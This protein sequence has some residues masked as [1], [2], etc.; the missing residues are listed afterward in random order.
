[1][2]MAPPVR[3]DRMR[4]CLQGVLTDALGPDVTVK[5]GRD[6]VQRDSTK[7]SM[8]SLTTSTGALT[9]GNWRGRRLLLSPIS[10]SFTVTSATIGVLYSLYLNGHPYRHEVTG[11]ETVDDVRDSLLAK[12]VADS[13]SPYGAASGAS[14]ELIVTGDYA[15]ALFQAE[16]L[17]APDWTIAQG[18]TTVTAIRERPSVTTLTVGSYS[19]GVDIFDGASDLDARV[20][21]ALSQQKYQTTFAN[22]GVS[23]QSRGAP[24]DISA[25]A[26][27]GW[28]TRITR[29]LGIGMRSISTE[30]TESIETAAMTSI[31]NTSTGQP[32][33]TQQYTLT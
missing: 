17:P 9:K 33:F 1:M 16:A 29:D 8:V 5:W 10:I 30:V 19:K 2:I 12:V 22:F 25:I 4:E 6:S 31:F 14:G 24:I 23:L 28:E 7:A 11:V 21:Q 18:A 15:G 13:R 3:F 20:D 26:G 27:A 32:I